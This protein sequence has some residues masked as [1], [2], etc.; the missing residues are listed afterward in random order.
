M[1]SELD[2]GRCASLLAVPRRG[3][4]MRRCAVKT[5]APN[6]VDL[7]GIPHRL[8]KGTRKERVLVRTLSLEGGWI[9]ISHIDWEGEQNTLYK[10]VET[11]PQ[12]TRFKA[13]R[14]SPKGKAQK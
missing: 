4:D 1:V 11:F 7:E 13:L 3:V 10:G 12:Q 14:G 8:E 2:T 5:R 9:V 6:G